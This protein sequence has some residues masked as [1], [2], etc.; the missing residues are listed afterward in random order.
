MRKPKN[1]KRTSSTPVKP[2]KSWKQKQKRKQAR[3]KDAYAKN[4][5]PYGSKFFKEFKGSW[6]N[7]EL[8][9]YLIY[10]EK[11][12]R[13][14]CNIGLSVSM[15]NLKTFLKGDRQNYST[16]PRSRAY[17]FSVPN[18]YTTTPINYIISDI[19]HTGAWRTIRVE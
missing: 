10:D 5:H 13:Y 1:T 3:Y 9:K 11:N 4:E 14:I 12:D 8:R 7:K 17:E 19:K 6:R 15:T 18:Y 2:K 16:G